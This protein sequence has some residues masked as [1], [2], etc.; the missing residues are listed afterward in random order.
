MDPILDHMLSTLRGRDDKLCTDAADEIERLA[1]AL[2]SSAAWIDRW[3]GHV[4]KCA[5]GDK[6]TCGRT[7]ILYEARTALDPA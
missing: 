7:A 4:G 5:G 3:T 2:G 6:C 1:L